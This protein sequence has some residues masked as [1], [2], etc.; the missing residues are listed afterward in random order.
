MS[1]TRAIAHPE[2]LR[3][4]ARSSDDQILSCGPGQAD[5]T[6]LSS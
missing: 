2:K 6:C 4:A 1:I 5:T 3:E